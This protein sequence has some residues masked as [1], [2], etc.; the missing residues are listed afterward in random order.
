MPC[1]SIQDQIAQKIHA[2]TDPLA[3]NGRYRD[4]IDIILLDGLGALP[5]AILQQSCIRVFDTRAGHGWPPRVS[6]RPGWSDGYRRLATD[7]GF[8]PSDVHVATGRVQAII[9]RIS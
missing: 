7:S 9:D 6:V 8:E 5:D 1:L 2:V 3:G 4:L